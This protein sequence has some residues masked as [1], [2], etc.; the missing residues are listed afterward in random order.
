[1]KKRSIISIV[2]AAILVIAMLAACSGGGGQGGGGG[3]EGG[4]EGGGGGQ[5]GGVIKIGYVNPTTGPLAGNGEGCDWVVKQMETYVNETLGGIEVDGTKKNIKVI[6][7]DSASDQATCAEMADKLCVEDEV[8]LIIAIQ[9]PETVIPVE[10]KAE[11]YGI[12]CVGIQ[13]PVNPCAFVSDEHNW[14]VHAFWT[15][16]KVYEQHKALWQAAGYAP[17]TGAKVG[18]AFANDS[19]GSAW[20]QIFTANLEKDGYVLVDPG[21]Y[22]SGTDDFSNIVKKYKEE[23]IDILAGTNIPPDFSNLFTQMIA[24]DVEVGC[25]T[26]GKC[27][28]LPGDVA[29]L[30]DNVEGIMSEVWWAP[31]YPYKS[32]LTGISCE[33]IGAKYLADNGGVM[34]QPAGYAYAALELAVQAFINAGTTDK[35]AV[36]AALKALDVETIVG[37]IK[38]DKEMNGLIY[39]DTVIAGGQWQKDENGV[40][41]LVVIDAT[42]YPEL[43]VAIT[44]QYIPGNATN[45]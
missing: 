31:N 32:G 7:Y 1:M 5:A 11:Q 37:P 22:P 13:A 15:I 40:W 16:E 9:T 36:F 39:G 3:Q 29:A 45:K 17:N 25:I 4:G 43:S 18:I 34:P 41:Q 38:Y 10:A 35:E 2:I 44:G 20:Y 8:D 24:A 23:N 28:L 21:Q 19:D 6:V 30:G 26:M 27:C 14:T 12:P 42:T 33:E